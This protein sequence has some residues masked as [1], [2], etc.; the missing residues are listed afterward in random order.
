MERPYGH[1]G[2]EWASRRG[3]QYVVHVC[4]TRLKY[5]LKIQKQQPSA[6]QGETD[7]RKTVVG[8]DQKLIEQI[9]M[10]KCTG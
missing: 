4:E 8:D 5:T 3:I 1:T 9:K 7:G 6:L 10:V 2:Q